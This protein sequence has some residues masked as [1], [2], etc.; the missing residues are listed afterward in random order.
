MLFV[1][2]RRRSRRTP[3]RDRS[4]Q[5]N[6]RSRTGVLRRSERTCSSSTSD[7]EVAGLQSA[8]GSERSEQSNIGVSV[9]GADRSR[10]CPSARRRP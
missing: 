5:S 6:P 10:D 7:D 4:E 1:H 8:I 9:W 2:E 3:K